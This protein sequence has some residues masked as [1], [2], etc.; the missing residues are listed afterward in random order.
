MSKIQ[1]L[2]AT[3]KQKDFSLVD[4]MNI[5]TDIVIANQDDRNEFSE[6][7]FGNFKAKMITT[8]TKGV[9][10][11]RNIALSFCDEEIL[12]F[13][14]DDVVYNDGYEE[15]I[16]KAYKDNPDADM[17]FFGMDLEKNSKIFKRISYPFKRCY[18]WNGLK[19]GTY[20]VSIKK[21]SLL[22][23]RLNY[24]QL[25]GGGCIY[26]S[27]EDS[28]FILDCFKAGLKAYTHPY[29]LGKCLKDESSWFKGHNEKYYYDK[30]V[31]FSAVNKKI[32]SLLCLQDLIRHRFY[33]ESGLTFS[34]AYKLMKNG[35]K[36][37]KNSVS[38]NE[39]ISKNN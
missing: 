6:K 14:D 4:K 1:V 5:Q 9:G 17:I 21:Q 18:V 39:F 37:Y 15:E 36:G 16:I 8:D 35:I 7:M 34:K 11:N 27:G 33:K 26:S 38:Y 28:L 20:V 31:L 32:A 19:F 23:Y 3:M 25:F 13:A 30:G 22:K 10:L 2:V 24:S 12:L 29:V